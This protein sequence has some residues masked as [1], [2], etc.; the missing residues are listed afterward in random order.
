MFLFVFFDAY[1]HYL[2]L[3]V[4]I[5]LDCQQSVVDLRLVVLDLRKR[6]MIFPGSYYSRL[7]FRVYVLVCLC[8]DSGQRIRDEEVVDAFSHLLLQSGGDAA[9]SLIM[10]C[11]SGQCM[12]GTCAFS[13]SLSLSALFL[14]PLCVSCVVDPQSP[15][16]W[17]QASGLCWMMH[18]RG[19]A[20]YCRM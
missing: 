13:L 5:C 16:L 18:C 17:S 20:R 7:V 12:F 1:C 9:C 11:C 8:S 4:I 2:S 19:R 6:S 15:S 10:S 14:S 3:F